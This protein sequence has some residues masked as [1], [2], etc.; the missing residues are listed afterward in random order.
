MKKV[1]KIREFSL[2]GRFLGFVLEEGYKIKYL[3]LA[4]QEREYWMKL[5]KPLRQTLANSLMPGTWIG[6]A[7][8]QKRH[9]TGSFKFKARQVETINPRTVTPASLPAPQSTPVPTMP[10]KPKATILVCQKSDCCKKGA[11]AVCDVL[12]KTIRERGLEDQ[13]VVKGTGCLKQCKAGPNIV[14]KPDKA[15]YSRIHPQQVP[16]VID[17]HFSTE[18]SEICEPA[19]APEFVKVS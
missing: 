2:Q 18:T 5:S 7:G 13:V 11:Q 15:R 1:N 6:V 8:E 9:K 17:Q 3:R 19:V 4:T 16:D 14:I 10:A 12:E